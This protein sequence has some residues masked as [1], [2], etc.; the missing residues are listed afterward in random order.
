[1]QNNFNKLIQGL[2]KLVHS[3]ILTKGS[4]VDAATFVCFTEANPL[5]GIIYHQMSFEQLPDDFRI[6]FKNHAV[7]DIIAHFKIVGVWDIW[8]QMDT[9]VPPCIIRANQ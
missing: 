8:L 1:M 7:G 3:G 9:R 5:G 2:T 6:I 4:Y